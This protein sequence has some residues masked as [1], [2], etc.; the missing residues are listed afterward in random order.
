M[1]KNKREEQKSRS[2]KFRGGLD[3]SRLLKFIDQLEALERMTLQRGVLGHVPV[4]S[5]SS[6]GIYESRR[7]NAKAKMSAF[8]KKARRLDFDNSLH[9][10]GR[11]KASSFV[12]NTHKMEGSW[13]DL[14]NDPPIKKYVK[15]W[16]R[17]RFFQT[18]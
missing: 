12:D 8:T 11:S 2:K 15:L 7:K 5:K 9:F 16:R 1:S 4:F 14:F 17:D 6:T 13:P 18:R 10:V 3:S